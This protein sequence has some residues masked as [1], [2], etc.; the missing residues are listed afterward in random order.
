MTLRDGKALEASWTCRETG[1]DD[2]RTA[3]SE[4]LSD[5]ADCVRANRGI[6]NVNMP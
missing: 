5:T 1:P 4:A 6:Q 3:P 2:R